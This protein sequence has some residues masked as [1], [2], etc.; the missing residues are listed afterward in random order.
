ME[1]RKL[2]KFIIPIF[3][4]GFFVAYHNVFAYY[5]ETHA[6]LTSEIVRFYNKN[7]SNQQIPE[8]LKSYLIDGSRREDDTPRW[9][10]HFYDPVYNRGLSYDPKIDPLYNLGTWQKS[11]DW[12]QDSNNQNKLTYKVPAT[13]A[14]ILTAIQQQKISAITTKTDFTWQKAIGLYVNGDKEKAIF[15]LGHI[16]HLIEDISIPDH[17]RNDAHA[18][19]SPYES[20]T[21][22]FSIYSPDNKLSQRLNGKGPIIS[23]GLNSSFDS[24]ANYSNNNFYSKD[25]IGIQSGYELPSPIEYE[26][27]N[28]LYYTL[29]KDSEGFYKISVQPVQSSALVNLKGVVTVDDNKVASDYWSRL[30]TKSI[31]YGAGVINLFFQEVEAAKND[32]NFAKA[33]E[34]SFF[35]K[36]IDTAKNL[37]AQIGDF[38]SDILTNNQDFQLAGQVSLEKNDD[39]QS[40]SQAENVQ[41]IGQAKTDES[42]KSKNLE[43][44]KSDSPKDVQQ[45]QIL[46]EDEEAQEL[47]RLQEQTTTTQQQVLEQTKT[48]TSTSATQ[49]STFK[50]CDF[51]TIQFPSRQKIIINEV[52]WMGT[53]NSANDEWIELK[54]ISGSEVNLTGWQLIDQG[55][56]I[57]INLGL[58]NKTKIPAG[59]FILL[60]RT[61]NDTVLNVSADFIYTGA[62]SNTNEGL[63]LF[64]NQCN[65]IDEVLASPDW[66]A[67]DNASATERK[68][69]ERDA[70][71][72]SWHTSSI[73]GGTPKGENST[74]AVVY[75]G[76]GGSTPSPQ[77]NP[78]VQYPKILISEI[79]IGPIAERFIELYNPNDSEV[80][81][82]NW[83]I[84][85]KTQIASEFTSFIS[86]NDFEGKTIPAN[87]YFLISRST[88]TD[89]NLVISD[90]TLTASNTIQLKNPGQ[91]IVDKVGYGSV[92]D[93]EGSGPALNPENNQS[94]QR[95]FQNDT[96]VDTDNNASDFEI[97]TCPSPK[98]QSRDCRLGAVQ[99][100]NLAYSS[101]TMELIFN[102][103]APQDYGGA[104]SSL[105]YKIIETTNASSAL[106]DV[107]TTST[108]VRVS[109][110]E[111]GRDY[112]FSIQAF[113]GGLGLATSTASTTV[114]SFFSGLYF[115][116]DPR[117][118]STDCLIDAYYNRYPFVP[119]LFGQGSRWKI[120]VFY[121]NADAERGGMFYEGTIPVLEPANLNNVLPIKFKRCSGGSIM[122]SNS[123]ILPDA[124]SGCGTDGGVINN[125]F[126]FGELEDN[127]FLI[128]LA[129]STSEAGFAT[130]DYLTIAYYSAYDWSMGRG[131]GF[132]LVAVDKIRYYFGNPATHQPPQLTG[133]INLN[134]D[135]QNSRLYLDWLKAVDLD[136]LDSLLT[137]EIQYAS[138]TN[139]ETLVG[140]TTGTIKIVAPGD[141]L[142]INVR[143]KDDFGNYSSST[144]TTNWS[145]PLTTF[146]ITQ[147]TTTTWSD[148]FGDMD[149]NDNAGVNFQSI[150]PENDFQFNKV[151]LK[152]WQ[153]Q[154][155][156]YTNLKLSIY[157][158]NSSNAPNFNNQLSNTII[159]NIYN[160]DKNQDITFNFNNPVSIAKNNK[161]WLVLEVEN[162]NWAQGHRNRW[163]NAISEND[164]Y[165]G[166]TAG[167]TTV[168]NSIYNSS[169]SINPSTDWYM[170]IGLE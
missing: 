121:L 67:G 145:Y 149:G 10:N 81:L 17:T 170:K 4:L 108:S 69:M 143:V 105:I 127:H 8:E 39:E 1:N 34:K 82:T 123:L 86:K 79:E 61:D 55:E 116:Q 158:D 63:R 136:T 124:A 140:N 109:T 111:V 94:I 6:Y 66:P 37:V 131:H 161:Y 137:Y 122:P 156:D 95:K 12:V 72:L 128:R 70:S 100:L 163:Q 102:W 47:L 120:L 71:G 40:K 138:S 154:A 29:G 65:L 21:E 5:A 99:N 78:T 96:F 33:E 133:S 54:N 45:L 74:P 97:Q 157:P 68:T 48:P 16:I 14:S 51:S 150:T 153:S 30:S 87:G 32:P 41:L 125:A 59:G 36:A 31:Q 135:R 20:Y 77:N 118:S 159:S 103:Q 44:Q 134:F 92:S 141:N 49:T 56:Q 166:G 151:V 43:S 169:I 35:S 85:R 9:M 3:I 142:S 160:P 13:I 147:I 60:E 26:K 155:N 18:L 73:V 75:S 162:Y 167:K 98:A 130:S 89:S 42:E 148:S 93:F 90:L 144:L 165:P 64:D 101:S 104:T 15:T 129:S 114:P 80:N 146:Y 28:D 11:K 46:E 113:D 139:W 2:I 112:E 119:D 52:A 91:E 88:S 62:L 50:E 24:L 107:E 152:I 132:K 106:P 168:K 83:Y 115:Y 58:M 53:A 76:G 22:Q 27:L 110:N 57:K 84:Q 23:N 25:T 164:P 7:F 117:A 38:V 19:G 126:D